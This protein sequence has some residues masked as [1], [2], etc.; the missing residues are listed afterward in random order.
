MEEVFRKGKV[1]DNSIFVL[2]HYYR[3]MTEINILQIMKNM[4]RKSYVSLIV[5]ISAVAIFLIFGLP[6]L[7]G[8]D[9]EKPNPEQGN[10]KQPASH[11]EDNDT[12]KA[13]RLWIK[14]N[15]IPVRT[16]MA[17]SGFKDMQ[18][19]KKNIGPAHLVALGEAT[20][21]TREFCQFKH[22]MLEFLINEMGFTVFAIEASMP[23]SFDINEYVLTGSGDPG[24]ALASLYNWVYNTE[25]VLDMIRWMRSYNADP[26]HTKKVKFYGFDM[27]TPSKAVKVT[28]ENLR[29]LDPV[30]A[31]TLEKPLAVLAN[32]FTAPDFVVLPKQKKEEATRAIKTILK[33]FEE[34]K[35]NTNHRES[36]SEWDIMCRQAVIVAQ[37]IE[38]KMNASGSMNLDPA[39]RDRSMTDNIRWILD[40]EGAETKMVISAHNLHVATHTPMGSILRKMYGNEMFV[41]GFAFNQGLF[42]A[43]EF[44]VGYI[45]YLLFPSEKG[46]HPFTVAPFQSETTMSMD[47][48]LAEA[49]LK[50]AVLNLQALP[51][52]GPVGRWFAEEQFTRNI[53]SV[54]MDTRGIGV[55]KMAFPE[56]YDAIFFAGNTMASRLTESGQ[57]PP[58]PI[59]KAPANL[60]FE[61]GVPGQTP[62]EWLVPKQS[63]AFDFYVATSENNPFTGKLCAV[64]SR[65]LERHY[66]E[67]YGSLSQMIDATPYRGKRIRLTAAILT[68]VSGSGNQAYLWLRVTKK[69]FGPAALL[70]YD[71][72]ADRPITSSEW[73]NYSIDCKVP[74]DADVIGYGLALVGEGQAWLDTV[75]IKVTGE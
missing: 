22:R 51:K 40:H 61:A 4:K 28:L 9:K 20:H 34:H 65:S 18:P 54:Y 33:L 38:S 68:A 26:L 30:Q 63:A 44:P 47:R 31:E 53:G 64:I 73:R 15:A 32:P 57:R 50:Y 6:Q 67:M 10:I 46:V 1:P 19:L 21:G 66:G 70:F 37:H 35:P 55:S 16:V 3:E 39:V 56:I 43:S 2:I 12:L 45:Q 60:D 8:S 7:K 71:N 13:V 59:L 36:V 75:S 41:F 48:M 62:V 17:G 72:M 74:E 27:Q 24:K 29:K 5:C 69:S 49:G 23:E 58:A 11:V 52:D 42:Q 14:H 25:E